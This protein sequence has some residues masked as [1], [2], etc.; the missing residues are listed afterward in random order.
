MT[1]EFRRTGRLVLA[2]A[3]ASV[4][5]GAAALPPGTEEE[6]YQRIKPIG[7][8][9]APEATEVV[10]TEPAEPRDGETVYGSY[11]T[12]CHA[13]GVAGAPLFGDAGAWE[14]RIAKGMDVLYENTFNGLNGVMPPRGTCPDC[15]DDE[16]RVAVDYMVDAAGG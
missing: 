8:L 7:T 2:A 14:A 1:L 11:C 6:I 13:S 15:S 4:A 16:L 12:A 3:L 10:D 5:I 9:N